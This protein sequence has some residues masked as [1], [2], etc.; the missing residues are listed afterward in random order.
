MP[1]NYTTSWDLTPALLLRAGQQAGEIERA[2]SLRDRKNLASIASDPAGAVSLGYHGRSTFGIGCVGIARDTSANPNALVEL[3]VTPYRKVR[4]EA[5]RP[6][7][8]GFVP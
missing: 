1:T 8:T 5:R 7:G 2:D 3:A 6:F 4:N